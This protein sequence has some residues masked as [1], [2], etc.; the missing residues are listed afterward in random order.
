MAQV[1][2]IRR[3]IHGSREVCEFEAGSTY[4]DVVKSLAFPLNGTRIITGD[5]VI[6]EEE[7]SNLIPVGNY[8]TV[9]KRVPQDPATITAVL[10]SIAAAAE[11]A[12]ATVGIFLA[13]LGVALAGGVGLEGVA[14]GA[15]SAVAG[16]VGGFGILSGFTTFLVGAGIATGVAYGLKAI[17]NGLVPVPSSDLGRRTA[18][19]SDSPTINGASNSVL[20]YQPIWKVYGTHRIRFPYA[21]VPYRRTFNGE[22]F[23]YGL[24]TAGYGPVSFNLSS[25][26]IGDI[27]L[28]EYTEV[29]IQVDEGDGIIYDVDLVDGTKAVANQ[30]LDIFS[31]DVNEVEIGYQFYVVGQNDDNW[32]EPQDWAGAPI[33]RSSQGVRHLECEFIF[34]QGIV[35]KTGSGHTHPLWLDFEVR[36]RRAANP[37]DDWGNGV[38]Q[39]GPWFGPEV[40]TRAFGD[41]SNGRWGWFSILEAT[42]TYTR[43]RWYTLR[44]G[45]QLGGVE[46]DLGATGEWDVQIR[47]FRTY[48]GSGTKLGLA[49]WSLLRSVIPQTDPVTKSGISL[50]AVRI[51]A[52]NQ[53][54]GALDTF[55]G[56]VTSKLPKYVGAS[57]TSPVETSNPAWIF[58]DI[59]RGSATRRPISDNRIDLT[60]VVEF[61]NFCEPI[62]GE[63]QWRFD[64]VFDFQTTMAAAL[65][66]VL[67][68][69]RSSYMLRD[70][71]HS[72][73]IDQPQNATALVTPRNSSGTQGSYSYIEQPHAFR[74]RFVN[75][76]KEWEQ[77]ERVIYA[78]G[79]DETTARVFEDLQ[80]FG[81]TSAEQCWKLADYHVRSASLKTGRYQ[82]TMDWGYLSFERGDRVKLSD[83]VLLGDVEWGRIREVTLNGSNE[84]TQIVLD[85]EV[86]Y[87]PGETYGISV[88]T[89]SLTSGT[90]SVPAYPVIN[91]ATTEIV[92][93]SIITPTN[94]IGLV[95]GEQLVKAKIMLA[96]GRFGEEVTDVQVYSIQPGPEA[97]ALVT[98]VDYDEA[99]FNVGAPIPSF[100]TAIKQ[101]RYAKPPAPILGEAFFRND[102]LFVP[103]SLANQLPSQ[104]EAQW[105]QAQVRPQ[106]GQWVSLPTQTADSTLLSIDWLVTGGLYEI[107]VRTD[108]GLGTF[109]DWVSAY[110][111]M[112]DDIQLNILDYRIISL[113]VVNSSDL[114]IFR[115][116]DAHFAWRLG[117]ADGQNTISNLG[118]VTVLV[119]AANLQY[120]CQVLDAQTMSV[121]REQTTQT[122]NFSYTISM[123]QEDPGPL[124]REFIFRV[125]FRDTTKSTGPWATM[126]VR[127]DPPADLGVS[128]SSFVPNI[129]GFLLQVNPPTDPDFAGI[130]VWSSATP[131]VQTVQVNEVVRASGVPVSVRTPYTNPY[132]KCAAFDEFAFNPLTG[133]IDASL[134]NV[135]AEFLVPVS[136]LI[137]TGDIEPNAINEIDYAEV[138]ASYRAPNSVAGVNEVSMDQLV[139]NPYDPDASQYQSL[140]SHTID[141]DGSPVLITA[142]IGSRGTSDNPYAPYYQVRRN[143]SEIKLAP[144]LSVASAHITTTIIYMDQNPPTGSVTYELRGA[145]GS[146]GACIVGTRTLLVQKVKR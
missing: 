97:S 146:Q 137:N 124:R 47:K 131:G 46:L 132:I 35:T 3:L 107:R 68:V 91:P 76:Q 34:P 110:Q 87:S 19:P 74:V 8:P 127:N 56:I 69:A 36:V 125:A 109:S 53:L 10:A 67:A 128:L 32:I 73:F 108:S 100:T 25:F 85:T 58:A 103:I 27:D 62:P 38:N 113:E 82:R 142:T 106:G 86:E 2:V 70:G 65:K 89:L 14:I 83:D 51:K 11:A 66:D 105:L 12:A 41:L 101:S 37:I 72:L 57:W 88:Q 92:K 22:Q 118:D 104:V 59:L 75:A 94:P 28:K 145:K 23:F 129:G 7:W 26:K 126:S 30:G 52:T 117:R 13:D 93:S 42:L 24:F 6:P 139:V 17:I 80:F 78:P 77:D 20:R 44:E 120:V 96:F 71:K 5:K 50:V 119:G 55:S 98:F 43:W 49:V 29:T 143:G 115:G 95:S 112:P 9:I 123:Q 138:V 122:P 99:V 130:V 121:V 54:N 79:Y 40:N 60:R 21:A 1:Y 63:Y 116:R 135:S 48:P 81:V 90:T 114:T 45:K 136:Q 84:V 144:D 102:T 33:A 141:S 140:L 111:D 15:G 31:T 39:P 134:L 16:A 61:A 4:S 133:E 64:G 18:S